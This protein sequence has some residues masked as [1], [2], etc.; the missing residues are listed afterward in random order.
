MTMAM[1]SIRIA[2]DPAFVTG[3]RNDPENF[4]HKNGIAL[5]I[6]ELK[7]LISCLKIEGFPEK[8]LK[9]I[10]WPDLGTWSP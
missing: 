2:T 1:L 10:D 8:F 9:D 3:L 7:S 6:D 5:S 4:L